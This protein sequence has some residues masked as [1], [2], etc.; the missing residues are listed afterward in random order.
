MQESLINIGI[1]Q[2]RKM[3]PAEKTIE[4]GDDLFIMEAT[5]SEDL[6]SF[7]YPCRSDAY[8]AIFCERGSFDVEINLRRYS[9]TPNTFFVSTPGNIIKF[10]EP[11]M[12]KADQI[13][14]VLLAISK[15][16]ISSLSFDM[17]KIFDERINLL[18]DPCVHLSEQHL[19]VCNQYLDLV[20]TLL[21][22]DFVNRREAIGSLV[23]SLF[24]A[25]TGLVDNN[26]D[27][28]DEAGAVSASSTR[29]RLLFKHFMDLVTVYHS[30]ER[31]MSFYADRL[32]LTPKYLSK[33]IKQVTGR[34]AP[35][36]IDAYVI[37]EAKNMLKYTD[38]SIKEIVYKLHFPNPSVFY[39]YFKTHTGMTPSEYRNS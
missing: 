37:L 24:Y 21:Q 29:M 6:L 9:V 14:F 20:K 10:I 36:W 4:M 34:S 27:Y 13:R 12:S 31:N 15:E 1:S 22:R 2:I 7:K 26:A 17:K 16:Y 19:K 23:S 8:L 33:L 35:D 11:D 32:G 39:K 18:T 25:L 30:S 5:Y 3:I 38:V 28:L